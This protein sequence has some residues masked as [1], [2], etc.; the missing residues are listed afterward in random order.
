VKGG[1][2]TF[3]AASTLSKFRCVRSHSRENLKSSNDAAAA[4]G[5][6]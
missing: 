5:F 4:G 2:R 1:N 3:A 6:L